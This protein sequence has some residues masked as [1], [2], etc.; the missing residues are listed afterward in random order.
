ML[1]KKIIKEVLANTNNNFINDKVI[2]S[3]SLNL[4][5]TMFDEVENFNVKKEYLDIYLN[6]RNS[7]NNNCISCF[8]DILDF[9]ARL[10]IHEIYLSHNDTT[11]INISFDKINKA[12]STNRKHFIVAK[13]IAEKIIKKY[14]FSQCQNKK[15]INYID[16]Y[17]PDNYKKDKDINQVVWY[18]IVCIIS[19]NKQVINNIS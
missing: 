5:Q 13:D 15:I 8:P 7:V 12:S 1:A 3:E 14:Y 9:S 4:M 18:F 17:L 2:I 11:T 10:I 19:F 16:D 6:F